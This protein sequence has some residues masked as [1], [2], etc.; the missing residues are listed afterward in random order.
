MKAQQFLS[1]YKESSKKYADQFLKEWQGEAKR[2]GQ[3]PGQ[4]VKK[5]RKLYPRGKQLRGALA[6][7]GYQIAGGKNLEEA[8]KASIVMELME[9]SILIADDVFDR[10]EIR[11]GI[12]TIHKQWERE[13]GDKRYKIGD[14]DAEHYGKSMAHTTTIVGF[15]LVPLALAE[16]DFPDEVKTKAL[17]FYC[18]SLINTGFGEALD[19]SSSYQ[20]LKRR[21]NWAQRIHDTKTVWYSA[22]LPLTFGA[23]LAGRKD[24]EWLESLTEYARALGRTFQIQDDIIGSFGD[25]KKTGKSNVSDIVDGRW[26]VLVE[27]LWK[28]A[29]EPDRQILIKIF[30][31]EKRGGREIRQVKKLMVKYQIAKLARQRAGRYLRK[32]LA[33]IPR[34]TDNPGHQDT[35]RNLLEFMM[36]RTK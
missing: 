32:G 19:I 35:M 24:K 1:W 2:F 20:P 22:I 28:R 26:T 9:T 27:L 5:F 7:L 13:T 29:S 8:L 3:I 12:P 34:I 4:M 33:V 17:N 23:I 36:E 6:V 31:K 21:Q 14:L 25:P 11:R 16:V 10:D 18:R 15:H 30:E